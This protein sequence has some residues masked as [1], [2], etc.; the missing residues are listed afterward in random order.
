MSL[1]FLA[2]SS[3]YSWKMSFCG[4]V[5]GQRERPIG[6]ALGQGLAGGFTVGDRALT[7]GDD[8]VADLE[9]GLLGGAP[10]SHRADRARGHTGGGGFEARR[11]QGARGVP[12]RRG[13]AKR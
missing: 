4:Q 1:T 7:D 12:G 3:A 8:D 2:K 11:R 13:L 5:D 6:L 10:A 9:P